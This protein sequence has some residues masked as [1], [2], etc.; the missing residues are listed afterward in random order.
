M[1]AKDEEESRRERKEKAASRRTGR[2]ERSGGRPAERRTW[3]DPG[4]GPG[5]VKLLLLLLLSAVSFFG[6]LCLPPS[7]RVTRL[8]IPTEALEAGLAGRLA[9]PA[10]VLDPAEGGGISA[11]TCA[12]GVGAGSALRRSC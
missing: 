2:Q 9:V 6:V 7:S 1:P 4:G 5:N 3:E 8:F 11:C 10:L 12:G